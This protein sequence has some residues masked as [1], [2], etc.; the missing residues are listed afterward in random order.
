MSYNEA[1]AGAVCA[2][3]GQV[4]GAFASNYIRPSTNSALVVTNPLED[5][6]NAM[7]SVSAGDYLATVHHVLPYA[8]G[9]G[10]MTYVNS[11]MFGLSK[12][13]MCGVV[14]ALPSIGYTYGVGRSM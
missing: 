11:E 14:G 4:I 9:V 13:V 5:V 10:Y 7:A 1:L 2:K 12:Y 3:I 8:L 6:K